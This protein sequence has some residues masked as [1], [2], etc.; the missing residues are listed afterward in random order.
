VVAWAQRHWRGL[1]IAIVE[2]VDEDKIHLHIVIVPPVLANGRLDTGTAHPG[3]GAVSKVL[4]RQA[5]EFKLSEA[6][7]REIKARQRRAYCHAMRE[8]Q[9]DFHRHV[10]HA[11]GQARLSN[12]PR[13]RVTREQALVAQA[14][15]QRNHDLNLSER[16]LVVDRFQMN[17]REAAVAEA[18]ARIARQAAEVLAQLNALKA[19]RQ[20]LAVLANKIIQSIG[21]RETMAKPSSMMDEALTRPNMPIS[22][23]RVASQDTSRTNLTSMII[24]QLTPDDAIV[25]E[26]MSRPANKIDGEGQHQRPKPKLNVFEP[27]EI[28]TA[29]NDDDD[30][31][32]G[33]RMTA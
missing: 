32:G 10:G 11:S 28:E 1:R 20:R 7:P 3:F 2:H 24:P 18:E 30:H 5:R 8:F 17:S 26:E 6:T 31:V 4:D 13:S 23:Q 27:V 9:N 15:R 25:W 21:Q 19:E 12:S 22:Y 14:Q 33:P 29:A 16:D